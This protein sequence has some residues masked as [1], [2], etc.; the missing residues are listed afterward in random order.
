MLG[1]G[2]VGFGLGRGGGGC[3]FGGF[4]GVGGGG[5]EL[6][7]RV[8]CRI[9]AG[10]VGFGIVVVVVFL[11]GRRGSVVGGLGEV[12]ADPDRGRA[13]EACEEPEL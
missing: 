12:G 9:D 5:E 1:L 6:G 7:F 13:E 2:L 11:I 10:F 4:F 3:C 8:G